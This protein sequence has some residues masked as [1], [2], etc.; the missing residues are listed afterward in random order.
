[1]KN[2][3]FAAAF[4]LAVGGTVTAHYTSAT[5]Q[6]NDCWS[7]GRPSTLPADKVQATDCPGAEESCCYQPATESQ[8]EEQLFGFPE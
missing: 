8:P 2:L 1:M 7:I 5:T 3:L 4:M 6:E